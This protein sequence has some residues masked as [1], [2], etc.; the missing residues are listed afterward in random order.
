V[1][2]TTTTASTKLK[3][4]SKAELL[5]MA[6][7]KFSDGS[8]PLGDSRY[9][10]TG[11]KKGYVYLCNARTG[12][13]GGAGSD[14]PWISGSTWNYL[15]KTAVSGSVSWPEAVFTN[16]VSGTVRKLTGNGL[17]INHTTGTFPIANTDPAS[18][19]DRNP[20]SIKAQ[21]LSNSFSSSPTYSVTPNCMGGGEVGMMLTGVPLFN[22]FDAQLRDAPAHELQDSCGGH[23]QKDGEYHYHNLSAC[24]KDQSVS[25]TLGFAADG[26]PITGGKVADKKFLT[27]EDLDECH[28]LTSEIVLDGKKVTTYHYVMT[29][30]FPY[31][32]S[33]FRG[34]QS[35]TQPA[36][37][38]GQQGGAMP[39]GSS[40]PPVM[41]GQG[42]STRPTGSGP[43]GGPPAE[44][45][46][47][48]SGKSKSD[49]CTFTT[50]M[51]TMT[52]TCGA[53]QNSTTLACMP[54]GG[55]PR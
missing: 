26:F 44:A 4:Y 30:D 27:T 31:S 54:A 18:T 12:E 15:T 51:G 23:P 14:G 49:S 48:C 53:P 22:A 33:C 25:T 7:N 50:P 43:Q 21:T 10:T 20:N 46:A 40:T 9:T 37:G 17:P 29:V 41:G 8:V 36:G 2:G 52:G 6:D 1:E 28:G 42:S 38:Q 13:E 34:T 3:V 19:Y 47:A 35:R 24:M 32:V 16:V 11:P 55:P 5:K 45:T 39:K